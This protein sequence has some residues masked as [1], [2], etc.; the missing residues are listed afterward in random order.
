MKKNLYCLKE[1]E[2]IFTLLFFPT[3]YNLPTTSL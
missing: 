1:E 3:K 2:A